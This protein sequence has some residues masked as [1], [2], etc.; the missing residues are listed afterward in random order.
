MA[1]IFA[2]SLALFNT[3][4]I[5]N[6]LKSNWSMRS[7]PI[8]T[9]NGKRISTRQSMTTM[10]E[11]CSN[12]LIQMSKTLFIQNSYS[13]TSWTALNQH[14]EF[15]ILRRQ[16]DW[17]NNCSNLLK[18]IEVEIASKISNLKLLKIVY[19]HRNWMLCT[20][21]IGN[22]RITSIENSWW[23]FLHIYNPDKKMQDSFCFMKMTKF[24]KFYSSKKEKLMWV[25]Q[26]IDKLTGHYG[27]KIEL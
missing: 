11:H 2:D 9:T 3:S 15:Q 14:S 8:S 20:L 21:N 23:I 12:S 6:H 13:E 26:L 5:K 18:L 7:K 1:T 27:S 10:R 24:K 25:L 16:K 4:M 17:T 19:H 22:G